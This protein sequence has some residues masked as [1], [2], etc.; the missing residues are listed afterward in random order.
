MRKTYISPFIVALLL[1]PSLLQASSFTLGSPSIIEGP[2]AG[3]DSVIVTGSGAWTA[4]ANDSWLHTTANGS[5]S[6]LA[7]F[8]FDSNAGPTRTGTLTVAGQTLTVIQAGSTYLPA[9]PTIALAGAGLS[10]PLGIAVDGSGNVYVADSANNRIAKWSPANQA[11]TT[12][13]SAGLKSPSGVAVDSSGN[14]IIADAGNLSVKKWTASTQSVTTLVGSGLSGILGVAV[15]AAGNVYIGDAGNHVVK[16]W[17]ASTQTVTTIINKTVVGPLALSLDAS[18][19]LYI[20]DNLTHSIYKWTAATQVLTTLVSGLNSP[21]G[22][23]V[24][25]SGNVYFADTNN[26]TLMR[27]TVATQSVT[28]LVGSGLTAP[29]GVALDA[30]GNVYLCEQTGNTLK[31]RLNAFVDASARTETSAAGTDA[32]PPVLPT[33]ENLLPPFAPSVDQ[34]WLTLNATINGVVSLSFSANT[35]SAARTANITVLG[36]TIAVTQSLPTTPPVISNVPPSATVEQANAAGTAVPLT[37]PT[38]TD[39]AGRPLTVTSN[40]PAVFPLGVTLVSFT[41]TDSNGLSTSANTVITVVD[42]TPP[43]FVNLPSS[44]VVE[45]ANRNGTAVS[46]VLPT[47]TDICDAAPHVTS[48]APAVFPLGITT[49]QFKATDASGNTAKATITITVRDTTPPV[50][51]NVPAPL[52]L[53]L[54]DPNGMP[55]TLAMPTATDICDAAPRVS[56]DAPAL[57]HLGVTTVT[58]TATDASGNSATATTTVSI[59]DTTA[60]TLANVPAPITVEQTNRDGTP[61][62]LPMPM[63]SDLSDAIVTSDAP[64]VF[65]LGVTTV[66]FSAVDSSGNTATA[67]TTVTVQDTTPPALASVPSPLTLE[68]SSA[69]GTPFTLPMPTATDICDAAPKVTSNAPAVFPTGV[70]TVVFTATDASGNSASASTTVTVQDT[71]PPVLTNVPAPVVVEQTNRDG[72][73]VTLALPA[74]TDLSAV[75]VASDAPAVFPLGVTT[76]HFTAIDASGNQSTAAT[77]VTVRDTTPP[78]LTN[79]PFPIVAEVTG[80]KGTAVALAM[81]A[82]V[83]ICDAAPNVISDA[84]QLFPMGVTTVTFTATDASGNTATA[85][86]TVTVRDTTPPVL[87]RVPAPIFAEQSSRTGT[88]VAI[89]M[90]SAT[91]ICDPAPKLTCDAP[92]L[93]PYGVTKVTFTATDASGNSSS[94]STTVTVQDTTPPVLTNVPSPVIVEQ[95][96]RAGT[97]VT[98]PLPTATDI[99]STKI[100][101]D[102]PAVFPLGTTT[103]NFKAVDSSG[104]VAVASTTVTVVDTTPPVLANVPA[105]MRVEQAAHDG[106]LFALPLPTATDICDAAPI[107]SSDAPALFPLGV[108]K[109]TFTAMDASGNAAH[110]STTV[111]VVDT[112]PPI[113][114]DIPAPVIAEQ[115]NRNGTPVILALP[116]A[117][118]VCDANPAVTS[119]APAVFPLGKTTVTFTAVDVSGNVAHAS[120]FVTIV[121]TTPPVIVN[122]PP[123]QTIKTSNTHGAAVALALPTATDIC[124]AAPRVTSDAP[125]IFP[126]GTTTV[127]FTATDASGNSSHASTTVQVKAESTTAPPVFSQVPGPITVEQA[128]RNGTPVTVPLPTAGTAH[129][130]SNA[131]ATFPLGTTTVTFTAVDAS[132]A[133]AT[134]STTVTVRDT[135]PPMIASLVATPSSIPPNNKVVPITLTVSASDICD[136]APV[137]KIVSVK[138]NAATDDSRP[139]KRK[140]KKQPVEWKI[141]GDLTLSVRAVHGDGKNPRVYTITVNCVDASGNVATKSVDVTVHDAHNDDDKGKK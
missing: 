54:T 129:V 19:N 89:P 20:A 96:N 99:N 87:A 2:G 55:V 67:S 110:A 30:N 113:I 125:S 41:A 34:S 48:D 123:P 83:D 74:A 36:K 33:T 95:S 88:P 27:W 44:I 23:A 65:P 21:R 104:N 26:N 28:T 139:G 71:T 68:L 86:T 92:A 112:T 72:T 37:L 85:T 25:G 32:L 16:L 102:A 57:F 121:D 39:F 22:V 98:L 117:F 61:V 49:V 90:P 24:D 108:T 62:A 78:V 4:A 132:G 119:D 134:A 69:S 76:V 64:A 13:V 73:P 10:T 116:H 138:T 8:S 82:A 100:T 105:P 128:N 6:G 122:V 38:A 84:Q 81:P 43:A 35:G 31:E 115:S 103:V 14:L 140:P 93:F 63:V 17:T 45:Q 18:G 106:T 53:E 80:R 136:A 29:R 56:S 133:T 94:A 101:S 141:T 135:T 59:V 91:D 109:V 11:L 9:N 118:D 66:H 114:S 40:A 70:T 58:F 107:V 15:D 5:A 126:I 124:D 137:S 52:T 79:V 1:I 51:S 127:T 47:A 131:P 7:L 12:L 3:T 46:L 75:R 130:T 42:T 97:P 77:T 60:P 111:T 50:L 120:T